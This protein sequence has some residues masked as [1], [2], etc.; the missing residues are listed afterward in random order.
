MMRYQGLIVEPQSQ[1]LLSNRDLIH[2]NYLVGYKVKGII[3]LF[4]AELA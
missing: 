3:F 4:R 2:K 1:V